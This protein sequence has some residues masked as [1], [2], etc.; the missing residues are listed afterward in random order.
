MLHNHNDL[1][2]MRPGSSLA[3]AHLPSSRNCRVLIWVLSLCLAPH[4]HF[5]NCT[6]RAYQL[7]WR[8]VIFVSKNLLSP[9]STFSPLTCRGLGRVLLPRPSS[10]QPLPQPQARG[11]VQ[12]RQVRCPSECLPSRCLSGL[13]SQPL[14]QQRRHSVA[15]VP[16][17]A[18][19]T[20]A[21]TSGF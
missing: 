11:E 15:R 3:P 8:Q 17:I 5:C 10:P 18:T 16:S 7:A 6:V 20:F 14:W 12:R 1:P 21:V 4:S 13:P 9:E 19:W 2:D